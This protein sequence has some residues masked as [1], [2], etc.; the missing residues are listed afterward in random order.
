M[1]FS[2]C[3]YG[4]ILYSWALFLFLLTH[5]IPVGLLAADPCCP[6]YHHPWFNLTLLHSANWW[7]I[8]NP[9]VYRARRH[10]T[11]H[12]TKETLFHASKAH[13][14][15]PELALKLINAR[16]VRRL[17]IHFNTRKI[18]GLLC[19]VPQEK[20]SH[21]TQS[22]S[23]LLEH[24][25]I[26]AVILKRQAVCIFKKWVCHKTQQSSSVATYIY[27]GGGQKDNVADTNHNTPYLRTFASHQYER[28]ESTEDRIG[29]LV[30]Q[31]SITSDYT[32]N[33]SQ[34]LD[35]RGKKSW[36]WTVQGGRTSSDVPITMTHQISRTLS[37]A[38][39]VCMCLA[40][41]GKRIM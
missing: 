41:L 5:R 10:S 20:S 11:Q 38:S 26:S 1:P 12:E 18:A 24:F 13:H 25:L 33:R 2:W 9:Q 36:D 15:A 22:W 3:R 40:D 17:T 14:F 35:L 30:H 6:Q 39:H 7:H 8:A 29:Q 34:C 19:C 16:C 32:Q 28:D 4:Y 21:R 27:I 31:S 23:E 37:I